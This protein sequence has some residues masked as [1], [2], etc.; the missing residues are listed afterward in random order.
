MRAKNRGQGAVQRNGRE[1]GWE[2]VG[3]EREPEW[4][5]RA[6]LFYAAHALCPGYHGSR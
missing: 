2:R 3:T 1:T 4:W 5:T 6:I